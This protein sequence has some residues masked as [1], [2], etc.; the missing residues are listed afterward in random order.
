M[1]LPVNLNRKLIVGVTI[2]IVTIF[3]I[4]NNLAG[5]LYLHFD[6]LDVKS[7]AKSVI[8]FMH[9]SP[10]SVTILIKYDNQ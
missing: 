9:C 5:G 2:I 8:G 7:A 3:Y 6:T 4:R 10:F 1:S